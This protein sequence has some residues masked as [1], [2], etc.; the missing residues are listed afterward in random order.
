MAPILAEALL[1]LIRRI[2]P[3]AGRVAIDPYTDELRVPFD[4]PGRDT[5]LLRQRDHHA[6]EVPHVLADV[7]AVGLQVQDW[8]GHELAG[9]VV[10]DVAAAA[11]LEVVDPQ[12]GARL[13]RREDVLRMG[14]AAERDDRIVLE[15]EERVAD[16]AADA[17]FDEALLEGEGVSVA[18]AAE[19]VGG[20]ASHETSLAAVGDPSL[21][22]G[23]RS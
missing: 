7:A 20:D 9:G 21:R 15:E 8:V 14:A 11:G 19:P 6:A 12:P 2:A 17:C 1:G 3:L 16:L 22:S 23:Y 10:R 13:F 18:H 5:V 4:H